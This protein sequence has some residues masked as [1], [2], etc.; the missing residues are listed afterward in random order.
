MQLSYTEQF[1]IG[2]KLAER[3]SASR[4]LL[5]SSNWRYKTLY[6]KKLFS[7]LALDLADVS[8]YRKRHFS[9]LTSSKT[10]QFGT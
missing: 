4:N 3:E 7:N 9:V 10:A 6:F 5:L 2:K 8:T 1:A